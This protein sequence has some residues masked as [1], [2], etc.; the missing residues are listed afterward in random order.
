MVVDVIALILSRV[1][2]LF[3]LPKGVIDQVKIER[4]IVILSIAALFGCQIFSNRDVPEEL[5]GLWETS[6]PRYENCWFQFED[7]MVIVQN[8]LSDVDF[9]HITDIEVSTEDEKTLYN[10]YYK[11]GHGG[12]YRFSLYYLKGPHRDVIRFKHQE[13]IA[14]LKREVQ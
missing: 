13:E 3:T 2:I 9:Y 10:I 11:D 5:V 14:W 8:R 1:K 12:E 4:I 6:V 7:K